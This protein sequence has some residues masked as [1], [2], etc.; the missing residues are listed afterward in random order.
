[1]RQNT[2]VQVVARQVELA[3]LSTAITQEF[4][5]ANQTANDFVKVLRRVVFVK[6]AFFGRI[7][8]AVPDAV[9]QFVERFGI[10]TGDSR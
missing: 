10:D 8:Y 1:M 4:A 5:G 6:N 3:D 9:N 7:G 2:Q